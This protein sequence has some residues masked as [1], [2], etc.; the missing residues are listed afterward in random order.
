MRTIVRIFG[1]AGGPVQAAVR[2]RYVALFAALA[3]ALGLYACSSDSP[4]G[5]D[6]E[7]GLSTT[8]IDFGTVIVGQSVERSF[9]ITNDGSETISGSVAIDAT[10]GLGP[11]FVIIGG[12]PFELVPAQQRTVVV[13][14]T[15]SAPGAAN[16]SV[17]IGAGCGDVACSGAGDDEAVCIVSTDTLD[18]G[19]VPVGDE[20]T[21]EVTMT[22]AGGSRITG[23]ASEDCSDFDILAGNTPYDLRSGDSLTIRVRFI[24]AKLGAQECFLETGSDSCA[25]VIMRGTGAPPPV[26]E[27]ST[28]AL[29]FGSVPAGESATRSF[30]I[31]NSGEGTLSGTLGLSGACVEFVV[32]GD[33]GFSLGPDQSRE[34]VVRFSPISEGPE[35]ICTVAFATLRCS[36][37]T[38]TGI[39]GPPALCAVTPPA[40]EFGEVFVGENATL[41]FTIENEG[42]GTLAGTV[43]TCAGFE[44]VGDASYSLTNGQSQ[45]FTLRFAPVFEGAAVCTLSLG[46]ARCAP[47]VARGTGVPPPTCLV[48]PAKL[49]F[50]VIDV[51]ETADIVLRIT[52]TGGGNVSGTVSVGGPAIAKAN[53]G[54]GARRGASSARGG[55]NA[56][57]PCDAFTIVGD[58]SYNLDAG[59]SD[60][61]IVRFA[62]VDEGESQCVIETGSPLCVDPIASGKGF[63]APQCEIE[64]PSL[65]FGMI[66]IGQGVDRA[67]TIRNAGGSV[68]AGT[69]TE[70][71]D[72]FTVV[73]DP[74]YSLTAGQSRVVTVRFQPLAEGDDACTFETGADSCIDIAA[75][76]IGTLF[77]ACELSVSSLDFQLVTVGE[78]ADL[79][80]TLTNNGNTPLAGTVAVGA[81]GG[82]SNFALVGTA[83]YDLAPAEFASFTARFAP[84]AEGPA[85]CTIE[86]GSGACIDLS[87]SGVG[88]LAAA[89]SL[90][91]ESLD[92]DT[93]S[94]GQSDSLTFTITNVGGSTLAGTVA[95]VC[96]GGFSVDAPTS[97][98]LTANQSQSFKVRFAPAAEGPASCVIDA[99]GQ[100]VKISAT[101]VGFLAPMCEVSIDTL[102]FGSVTVGESETLTFSIT[103]TGG[104]TLAGTLT[105]SCAAFSIPDPSYS[106]TAGD[107]MDFDVVFSPSIEGSDTC[108]IETGSALCADVVAIG[109][110]AEALQCSLSVTSVDFGTHTVGACDSANVVITNIG[111][112]T[113]TGFASLSCTDH[114][115]IFSGGGSF[116][117]LP[118]AQRTVKVRFAPEST[119]A[120]PCSLDLGANCDP[121]SLTGVGSAAPVCDL[122]VAALAF[123]SV[124]VNSTKDSTFTIKNDGG[125]V[126]NVTVRES[127][128]HYR[129][130]S[131]STF[132]LSAGQ[133]QA[134]TIRFAPTSPGTKFCTP[135][136]EGR[137]ANRC[138]AGADSCTSALSFT[139]V[140]FALTCEDSVSGLVAPC[141]ACHSDMSC[142]DLSTPG[143]PRI[144]EPPGDPET[145]LLL[146]KA[147]GG[148]G[149]SGGTFWP[150]GSESYNR[151]L[152]WIRTGANP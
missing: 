69:V 145:S 105:E 62:P 76:G 96:G 47:F 56:A 24:P 45:G 143:N 6:S 26:C 34:F 25:D 99:G 16:S 86:T 36:E 97:Y 20:A 38:L 139:G 95:P 128:N 151:V 100:C 5:P 122:S 147:S 123:D 11:F 84:T 92:F 27:L 23:T 126:L 54:G 134:V 19:D 106:L 63:I 75:T 12:G 52:N 51:G 132:S 115:F 59:E 130:V 146:I 29:D 2:R 10:S 1:R 22:N 87:A 70:T 82:C 44:I 110:G 68:L 142:E 46:D 50:G 73:G 120:K 18:F 79:P 138:G 135:N 77:S 28:S 85:L 144:V 119:G 8:S 33:P 15:P 124:D 81:G 31:T 17:H 30:T 141:A 21:L 89:C 140:G 66:A 39:G 109:A 3:I 117:L 101:G 67:L 93:V 71:C 61:V 148:Q 57:L 127:C 113:L 121:V 149:H 64:P 152:R 14:F 80:F 9:T 150:V 42:Q 48:S 58:A 37:L 98:S 114:Y 125:G 13:R 55:A 118:M 74:S 104:S 88:F 65:D 40:L 112:Q 72:A 137:L 41:P 7:C 102:D 136:V 111:G 91:V 43:T 60:S 103:N 53:G 78:S 116:S 133:S 83:D 4:S 49:A 107:S 35:R 129:I 90:S 94:V 108:D 32:E 131:D